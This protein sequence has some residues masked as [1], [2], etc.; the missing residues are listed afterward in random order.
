MLDI[1]NLFN[2]K[3]KKTKEYNGIIYW[4]CDNNLPDDILKLYSESP[5]NKGIITRKTK[6]ATGSDYSFSN[7][8]AEIFAKQINF[9]QLFYKTLRDYF[10]FGAF[11]LQL[12][13]E[14]GI[15]SHQI[16]NIKY[17]D[18]MQVRLTTEEKQIAINCDWYGYN[19]DNQL[20]TE[21]ELGDTINDD[22]EFLFYRTESL[23]QAY[24]PVPDWWSAATSIESE[25][26][27][28]QYS[29]NLLNQSFT[30]TGIL[31]LPG[32]VSPEEVAEIKK[33][34]KKELTGVD[35]AGKIMVVT[36]DGENVIEWTPL[37]QNI[38]S[39]QI[40]NFLD[41]CRKS[42]II[43]HNLPSPT[44]IGLPGGASLGGDGN[45]I[46]TANK[47]FFQSDILAI[48]NEMVDIYT[49]LFKKAG[50]PTTI[51]IQN[52]LLLDDTNTTTNGTGV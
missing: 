42:I 22:V 51:T 31:K 33:N 8:Q 6:L 16:A 11:S 44:I 49:E 24:Y 15:E 14:W 12:V 40:S 30:P 34:I 46:A 18:V 47:I 52:K 38:D 45:T 36:A 20:F 9:K 1:L 43:A 13:K 37:Q 26:D 50:F 27:L 35:N 41:M 4:G 3:K 17:Q 21:Y 29:Q 28:L 32:I 2:R 10:T 7:P 5:T 23:G 48:Q 39:T 19:T 25:I